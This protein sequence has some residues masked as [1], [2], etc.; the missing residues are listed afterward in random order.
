[1]K[2]AFPI[3]MTIAVL[4]Y[5]DMISA[6]CFGINI[7]I[8]LLLFAGLLYKYLKRV[9]NK[10]KKV[11][12]IPME[13]TLFVLTILTITI[14]FSIYN[15]TPLFFL[16]TSD[17]QY[18]IGVLALS[19]YMQNDIC[20]YNKIID[21]CHIFIINSLV[22]AAAGGI[23]FFKGETDRLHAFLGVN[24]S[25]M[26]FVIAAFCSLLVI[27][28]KKRQHIFCN[29]YLYII[30]IG[31]NL[32]CVHL[33]H[34]SAALLMLLFTLAVGAI[35]LLR[36]ERKRTYKFF[37]AA[38]VCI[39]IA[40]I[41]ITIKGEMLD[42]F[43]IRV[44]MARKGY[45]DVSRMYTWRDAMEQFKD[46]WLIGVGAGNFREQVTKNHRGMHNDYLY[47][48][49][50]YGIIGFTAFCCYSVSLYKKILSVNYM[51]PLIF[52]LSLAGGIYIFILSHN[53]ISTMVFWIITQMIVCIIN[54]EERN[55]GK[56]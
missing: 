7:F 51:Q 33:N 36:V 27:I 44:I 24:I 55:E 10:E 38:S 48:L 9:K 3:Y 47:F 22:M 20:N 19:L 13:I 30:V 28:I 25:G 34:S 54:I 46:H 14:L 56:T 12:S 50:N 23:A 1:M 26:F 2:I 49:V 39:G 18:F 41:W 8:K 6:S 45:F 4:P 35:Y 11:F 16:K 21:I 29:T 15:L 32:L 40:S 53:A 52:C 42:V 5:K 43:F 31:I 17:F 37:L